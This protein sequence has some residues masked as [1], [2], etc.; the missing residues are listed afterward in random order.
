MVAA[1]VLAGESGVED[2]LGVG[3]CDGGW[4]R[5][6]AAVVQEVEVWPVQVV[7]RE[8]GSSRQRVQCVSE[9][10]SAQSHNRSRTQGLSQTRWANRERRWLVGAA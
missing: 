2:G 5:A 6:R 7:L 3:R 8:W 10:L 1:V 9:E 4:G